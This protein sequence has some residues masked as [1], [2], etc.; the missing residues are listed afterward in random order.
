[1]C[2]VVGYRPRHVGADRD[3]FRKLMIESQIRGTHTYGS[4][5]YGGVPLRT[6]VLDEV[7]DIFDP[8]YPTIAHCRFSTSGDWRELANAQPIIVGNQALVFNGVISM[9]LKDEYENEYG[10]LCESDNDGEIPL[11]VPESIPDFVRVMSGSFAGLLLINDEI[12]AYRNARRP[13]WR[14]DTPNAIWWA[15]TKDI[16]KRAG[17]TGVLSEVPCV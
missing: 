12:H 8:R 9:A 17:I 1:M 14:V 15:S 5:A 16:L 3:Q 6:F 2:A 10:V 11:R 13:L 4:V 7:I